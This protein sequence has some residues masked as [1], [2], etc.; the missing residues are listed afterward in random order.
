MGWGGGVV[1]GMW[2]GG[3]G[4]TCHMNRERACHGNGVG[5]VVTGMGGGEGQNLSHE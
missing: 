3:R 2:G 1:T 4:R 5:G